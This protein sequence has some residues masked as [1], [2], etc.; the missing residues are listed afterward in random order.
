MH[1][2]KNN[3]KPSCDFHYSESVSLVRGSL[4]LPVCGIYGHIDIQLQRTNEL[5][6]LREMRPQRGGTQINGC[7]LT[8]PILSVPH[9]D[10]LYGSIWTDAFN[11]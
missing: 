8:L 4:H 10:L 5:R 3:K 9:S 2:S 6:W 1:L 7:F 11:A